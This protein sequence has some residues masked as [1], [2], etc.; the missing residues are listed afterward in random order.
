M[1]KK[2]R[3]EGVVEKVG[4]RVP[5]NQ[6]STDFFLLPLGCCD[7]V[8]GMQ[9]LRTLGPVLWDFNLLT[10]S[11]KK[12][13]QSVILWGLKLNLSPS[14]LVDDVEICQLTTLQRKGM[15]LQLVQ[16][17]VKKAVENIDPRMEYVLPKFAKVFK[18]PKE[19]PPRRSKD[20]QINL[21]ERTV[22]I[23]VK[24]YRYPFY[25]KNVN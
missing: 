15:L 20:Y 25:Q 13:K 4:F 12:D 18:E 9:W 19:L 7:V 14:N 10:M 3:I 23:S 17:E 22:P 5:G 11:F 8:L 6:F 24:P 21:K 16:Q 1:E 2:M